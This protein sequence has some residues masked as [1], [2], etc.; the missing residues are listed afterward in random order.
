MQQLSLIDKIIYQVLRGFLAVLGIL[1][2]FM[3][4]CLA[5]TILFL[6]QFVAKKEISNLRINI[7]EILKLPQESHFAKMFEKQV[8]R[9]QVYAMI[10]S[11][12]ATQNPGRLKIHNETNLKQQLDANAAHNRGQIICTAHI[13]SWEQVAAVV[14]RNLATPFYVLAKPSGNKGVTK[15]LNDIRM[16][17]NVKVLWTDRSSIFK[18]MF[19]NIK[20]NGAI[21]FV[22]DQKPENRKGPVVT[23]FDRETEFVAGPASIAVKTG[24]A[25]IAVNV[26]E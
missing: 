5:E 22:M 20:S 1:P 14:A 2:N 18:D 3:I 23:F 16:D 13:G 6:G 12:I 17:M 9:H 10:E 19:K 11:M 8:F 25:V 15:F 7:K 24:C 26:N 4:S 21:G